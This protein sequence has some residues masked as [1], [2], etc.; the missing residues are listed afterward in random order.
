MRCFQ[1]ARMLSLYLDDELSPKE[2]RSIEE[3]LQKCSHCQQL[4]ND[5]RAI[6]EETHSLE[7]FT[8]PESLW[9]VIQLRLELRKSEQRRGY[10]WILPLATYLK[11]RWVWRGALI[12]GAIMVAV[13][14][15][16]R[17]FPL[18]APAE[19]GVYP[20]SSSLIAEVRQQLISARTP[21]L[22]LIGEMSRLA[23]AEMERM[24]SSTAMAFRE[25]LQG[26]DWSIE[27][28]EE[29]MERFPFDPEIRGYLFNIYWE[30]LNLLELIIE[31]GG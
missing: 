13:F 12:T 15:L 8:P 27:L 14:T 2:K 18:W 17:L 21:Y 10:Q 9:E 16:L 4:L 30:K 22:E 28:C 20:F 5:L 26:I 24:D 3:H 25:S 23:E 29:E 19:E 1:S 6:Q 11:R 31:G 7:R